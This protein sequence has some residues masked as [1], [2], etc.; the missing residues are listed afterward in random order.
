[1]LRHTK[2]IRKVRIA[3]QTGR[4]C[5]CD[6]EQ[7]GINSNVHTGA[8]ESRVTQ[9]RIRCTD[10]EDHG[11]LEIGPLQGVIGVIRGHGEQGLSIA[12]VVAL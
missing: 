9:E 8:K 10:D 7:F 6:A 11:L 3:D 5:G 1:M 4:F 2:S 12:C